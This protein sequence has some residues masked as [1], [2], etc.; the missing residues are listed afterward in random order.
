MVFEPIIQDVILTYSD[1]EEHKL[2]CYPLEEM[3]VEKL[4]SVMQRMQAR[5]LYDIW[6]LM[7]IH[8]MD[9]NF[10]LNEFKAKC[11]SKGLKASDFLE[12][13]EQRLPQY[14]G[15]WQKSMNEQIHDSPDF[16]QVERETLRY[17]RKLKL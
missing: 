8:G 2:L 15:R 3:L 10:Y 9:I 11:E 1:Q 6:Y 5:D 13:L 17:L 12:K 16:E 7:E 4:R 14:K